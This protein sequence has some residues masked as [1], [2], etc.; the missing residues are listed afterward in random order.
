MFYQEIVKPLINLAGRNHASPML[1]TLCVEKLANT[2]IYGCTNGFSAVSAKISNVHFE[3]LPDFKVHLCCESLRNS[4]DAFPKVPRGNE[5]KKIAGHKEHLSTV[6]VNLR[7]GS[8]YSATEPSTKLPL[9]DEFIVAGT[10]VKIVE[11]VYPRLHEYLGVNP[12]F[13]GKTLYKSFLDSGLAHTLSDHCLVT[14]PRR[15][16]ED[17]PSTSFDLARV[18]KFCKEIKV[19]KKAL[20][21]VNPR[22]M[23]SLTNMAS[24]RV[25][26]LGGDTLLKI[27]STLKDCVYWDIQTDIDIDFIIDA[28][29]HFVR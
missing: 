27:H 21:K 25:L 28:T 13:L 12:T 6:E 1:N 23:S 14:E 8:Q 17:Y 10:S 24:A 4:L 5:A 16:F 19:L 26:P 15:G 22:V 7:G 29:L 11:G 3:S 20:F 2:L 9:G 18:E